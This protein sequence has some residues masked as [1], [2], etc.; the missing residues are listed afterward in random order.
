MRSPAL[1]LALAASSALAWA[2]Q[3][4]AGG[5]N[6]C[7]ECHANL[8]DNLGRP[9]HIFENDIHA[10]NGFTCV[11]CHGGDPSSDDMEVS[12]SP[13]RGFLAKISRQRTPEMCGR[14]HGDPNVIHKF[15]PQQRVDQLVQYRTSIHGKRLAAGD[16]KVANC[17]DCHS[18]HDIREVRHAL[19]PVHPLKLPGTCG[20]CHADTEHMS[21]YEIP[22]TQLAD[23]Q[24]SIHWQV[25]SKTGDLS[26][27]TCA[28]CHGNHGAAPPGVNDVSHVC[29]TCHVVFQ[30]LFDESPHHPAFEAMDLPACVACHGNHKVLPPQAEMLGVGDGAVCLDCHSEGDEGYKT[31]AAMKQSLDKI[32]TA[33]DESQ[34]LLDRAEESGMEVSEARLQ[35]NDAHEQLIKARVQVH[36]FKLGPV[37]EAVNEGMKLAAGS[38]EKGQAALEERDFRRMGLAVAL[39][40]IALTMAGLWMAVKYVDSRSGAGGSP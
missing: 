22:T 30:K 15:K 8:E 14:C 32:R 12:M 27:P 28:T 9:A 17:I 11:D 23:Y 2:Q 4:L 39:L 31:A 33:L 40:A 18:V 36:A 5:K 25:I 7:L 38:H 3:S 6:S 21:G 10:Q 37:D 20:K 34:A 13:S 16:E 24:R 1:L 29:G 35:W 26:A 19:S